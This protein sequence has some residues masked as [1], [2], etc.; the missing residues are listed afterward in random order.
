MKVAGNVGTSVENSTAHYHYHYHPHHPH[1]HQ[2]QQ[3]FVF[4]AHLTDC[5]PL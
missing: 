3:H 4:S 2:Q 5:L 1:H